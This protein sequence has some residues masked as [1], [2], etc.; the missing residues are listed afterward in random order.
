MKYNTEAVT[1]SCIRVSS[2]GHMCPGLESGE[3]VQPRTYICS[4]FTIWPPLNFS[5]LIPLTVTNEWDRFLFNANF[6]LH[7]IHIPA[8]ICIFP[9]LIKK[10]KQKTPHFLLEVLSY[11]SRRGQDTSLKDNEVNPEGIPLQTYVLVAVQLLSSSYMPGTVLGAGNAK[12]N[13]S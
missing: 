9:P 7:R 3:A 11:W 2:E 12:T 10:Q 6:C 13:K 8:I 1:K 5:L 4:C